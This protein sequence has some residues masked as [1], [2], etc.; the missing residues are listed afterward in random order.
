MFIIRIL[1]Y[2]TLLFIIIIFKGNYINKVLKLLL[3][4]FYICILI[5]LY[6]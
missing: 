1:Y 4:Y 6:S 5:P 3:T 2:Y